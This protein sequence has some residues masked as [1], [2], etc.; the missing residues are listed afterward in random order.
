MSN[1][2]STKYEVPFFKVPFPPEVTV[3]EILATRSDDKLKSRAPNRYLIY[4]IAFLKELRKRTND[5]VPMT[6]ISGH[7]SS[8]WHNESAVVR[9]A[10]KTLSDQVEDRLKE[11]RQKE[12]LVMITEFPNESQDLQDSPSEMDIPLF[13]L[14]SNPQPL[15]PLHP[16][17]P[18]HSSPLSPFVTEN[19]LLVNQDYTPVF[20]F[21]P[22]P[23]QF[24]DDYIQTDFEMPIYPYPID[25]CLCETCWSNFNNQF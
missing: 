22:L 8:L 12:K 24:F 7:I 17:H 1:K 10:Y 20:Y 21:D 14:F 5:N 23:Y 16:Q 2:K 11:I 13:P 15:Q 9:D 3:E 4:R 18:Q 19:H 25:S 6:K